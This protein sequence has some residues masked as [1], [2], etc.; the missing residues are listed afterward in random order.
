MVENPVLF[1]TF[2]RPE[3]ARKSWDAIKAAKPKNLYF[4]SNKGR[5]EKEG[6]VERNNEIRAYVKEIDWECNLHTW[7]RDTTVN[8]YESLYG[9]I[10]WL[11]ENEEQGIILEE[12]CVASLA[13]FDYCDQLLPRYKDDY[14]IWMISGDNYF[15]N[16]SF[17]SCDYFYSQDMQIFGWASWRNR[18]KQVDWEKGLVFDSA[19]EQNII[20][21][22]VRLSR[23]K[24]LYKRHIKKIRNFVEETN[25]W[26]YVFCNW[27]LFNNSLSIVPHS[28]LVENIGLSGTHNTKQKKNW[29]NVVVT[30]K[31]ARYPVSKCPSFIA[32]NEKY[33]RLI[34]EKRLC[35]HRVM[36]RVKSKLIKVIAKAV[37]S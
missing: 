30:Y 10:S 31:D 22:S 5:K 3:Y 24:I 13:F 14:R 35:V 2:A 33:D 4:Y 19:F 26:D 34:F 6:E 27:G 1:I 16:E 11:F 18:W 7:F 32:P 29:N 21:I 8:V 36:H 23:Y 15:E 25:C 12:D 9:A 28:N 17:S 20:E 37:H